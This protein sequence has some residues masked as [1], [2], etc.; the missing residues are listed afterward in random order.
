MK[1]FAMLFVLVLAGCAGSQQS[2]EEGD[3]AAS[4][5]LR[6]YEAD[7][8]PSDHD[9]APG[10][11]MQRD[12]AGHLTGR[13]TPVTADTAATEAEEYVQGFRVQIFSTTN[14]DAAQARKTEAESYFPGEWIYLEYD[15]PTYK[16]RVGNFRARYEADRFARLAAEKGFADAWTVP[17]KVLRHPGTPPR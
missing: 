13:E 5:T 1:R 16:I 9:P 10:N 14:I 7:F 3:A 8:R 6:R 15:P 17:E 2:Q 4:E 11:A 12:S